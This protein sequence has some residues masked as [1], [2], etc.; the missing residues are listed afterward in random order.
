MPVF[1]Q[2]KWSLVKNTLELPNWTIQSAIWDENG[3]PLFD[4]NGVPIINEGVQVGVP[5]NQ[6]QH[7][8]VAPPPQPPGQLDFSKKQQS[9]WIPQVT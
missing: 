4:E 3:L 6:P 9:A 1:A 2:Q 7:P 8:I 5:P